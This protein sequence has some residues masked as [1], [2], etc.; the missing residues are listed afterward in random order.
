MSD[1]TPDWLVYSREH[2]AFWRPNAAGYTYDINA[3][4]RYTCEQAAASAPWHE[5]GIRI[6]LFAHQPCA[7]LTVAVAVS[8]AH[9]PC[10]WVR[11]SV[12]NHRVVDECYNSA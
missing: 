2:N 12:E 1:H 8:F 3:A 5:V 9:R 4:G 11:I 10:T 7:T 6:A